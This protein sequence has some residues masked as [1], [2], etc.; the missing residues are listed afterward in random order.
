MT[1][2]ENCVF[3]N[4]S[5]YFLLPPFKGFEGKREFTQAQA[6]PNI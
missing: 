3:E 6:A 2:A 4:L 1:I 5:Y